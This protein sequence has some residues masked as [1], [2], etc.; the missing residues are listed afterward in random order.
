MVAHLQHCGHSDPKAPVKP[1]LYCYY[2]LMYFYTT[3]LLY[4]RTQLEVQSLRTR[5]G[6]LLTYGRISR[7]PMYGRRTSGT[8]TPCV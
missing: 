3:P 4:A 5:L 8:T 6:N 7:P 1:V 2:C